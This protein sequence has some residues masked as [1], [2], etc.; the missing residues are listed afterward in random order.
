MSDSVTA[1]RSNSRCQGSS[2]SSLCCFVGS[3]T[4]S[5]GLRAPLLVSQH[6]KAT[7]SVGLRTRTFDTRSEQISQ[8]RTVK[9]I[10]TSRTDVIAQHVV[11]QRLRTNEDNMTTLG[12]VRK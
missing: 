6:F 4:R 12:R 8:S 2:S 5:K 7:R 11:E 1:S 10:H 3:T 9:W